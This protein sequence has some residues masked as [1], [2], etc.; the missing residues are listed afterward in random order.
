M[1][2]D[3]IGHH[4]C[5]VEHLLRDTQFS[6]VNDDRQRCR[7]SLIA[8]AGIDDN[9]QVAAVHARVRPGRGVGL[10]AVVDAHAIRLQQDAADVRAVIPAQALLGDGPVIV[11][12]PLERLLHIGNVHFV[13]KSNDVLDRQQ[14]AV[15]GV[16]TAGLLIVLVKLHNAVF[17]DMDHV[18]VVS[19]NLNGRAVRPRRDAHL[20]VE[21]VV[22][23]RAPDGKG[24]LLQICPDRIRLLRRE[25]G[26]HLQLRIGIIGYDARRRGRRNAALAVRIRHDD[27]LDV[28]DD[29]RTRKYLYR[30]RQRAECL[31][32]QRRAV[33]HGNRLGT[34]HGGLQLL[35]Q[36]R[37]VFAIDP[38]VHVSLLRFCFFSVFDRKIPL[39]V[40]V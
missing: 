7:Q 40:I 11:D 18:R 36:D 20:N 21:H 22:L 12:L 1:D 10:G 37:D 5:A 34:A 30:F 38:F 15:G 16:L 26:E 17:L 9:R 31:A 27:T 32:S 28:F 25:A 35:F 14:T 13:C 29:V 4:K 39:F 33:R 23:V 8:A 2:G 19:R 6:S 24:R 3:K